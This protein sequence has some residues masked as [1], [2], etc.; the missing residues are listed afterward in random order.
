MYIFL[1]LYFQYNVIEPVSKNA[2][3]NGN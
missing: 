2:T 1:Q 3:K